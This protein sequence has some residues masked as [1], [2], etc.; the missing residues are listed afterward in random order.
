[1]NYG[2]I[3]LA[4]IAATVAYYI[5]GSIGGVMFASY[6]A[7]YATVFRPRDLILE[8]MPI[9]FAGTF[10]A[11]LVLATIYARG[12]KGSARASEGL[13][14]G[15]LIGL[16]LIGACTAHDYVIL[17]IR[18]H[19]AVVQAVGDVVGWLVACVAIACIYRPKAE[20]R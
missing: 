7:Q 11:A 19:L 5:V 1:M 17:N 4:A 6:Y 9:G 15:C 3:V 20:T 14:F 16:F 18:L 12:N 8:Y 2:R 13:L 10:L